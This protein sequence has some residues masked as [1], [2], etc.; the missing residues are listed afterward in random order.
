MKLSSIIL[1]LGLGLVLILLPL[2]PAINIHTISSSQPE[3]P[4]FNTRISRLTRS[5]E[6]IGYS[7]YIG[8]HTTNT[9]PIP[10]RTLITHNLISQLQKIAPTLPTS[11]QELQQKW[12][13][14]LQLFPT[15]IEQLNNVYRENIKDIQT[16]LSRIKTMDS[17]SLEQLLFEELNHLK[18]DDLQHLKTE[19]Q[20]TST[21]INQNLTS[22]IICNITSGTIC[23]ITTQPVCALTLQPLC[24]FITVTPPCLTLMG[25][26][27]PTAGLKC[28]TPTSGTLCQL[29]G[30]IGPIIKSI[31]IIVLIGLLLFLPVIL[32]V[33]IFAPDICTNIQ[34]RITVWLNC[35]TNTTDI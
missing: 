9:L 27:C 28:N 12:H 21:Q 20:S 13:T 10:T 32:L 6:S 30:T 2:T 31:L 8:Q 14:L 18:M 29:W 26:R 25:I 4:L 16:H 17:S 15:L 35:S 5:Y 23:S 3:N 22:G 19:T 7:S 34:N 33:T 24:A 1:T 11:D